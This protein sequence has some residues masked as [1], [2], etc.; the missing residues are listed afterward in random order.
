M[1]RFVLAA[2]AAL[3]CL[4]SPST[5]APPYGKILFRNYSSAELNV[6]LLGVE[7]T[8]LV[9]APVRGRATYVKVDRTT[10]YIFGIDADGDGLA[11][12]VF[13]VNLNGNRVAKVPIGDLG[14]LGILE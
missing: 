10:D 7:G 1:L 5:A 4:A 14:L 13:T 3:A 12:R 6:G 11:E 2:A 9:L 8:T